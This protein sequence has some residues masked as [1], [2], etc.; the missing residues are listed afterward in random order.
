MASSVDVLIPW[1]GND[2]H[3]VKAREYVESLYAARFPEWKVTLGVCDSVGWTKALAVKDAFQRTNAEI[4][5]VADA[6]VWCEEIGLVISGLEKAE[7]AQPYRWV[8]RITDADTQRVFS[9]EIEARRGQLA[10]PEYSGFAGGGIVAMRRETYAA[11]PLDPRFVGW[12]HEDESWARALRRL[13]G[14]RWVPYGGHLYHFWHPPQERT[15]ERASHGS[16]ESWLLREQYRMCRADKSAMNELIAGI[17][18]D[19]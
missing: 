3:R 11:C 17:R 1:Q 2:P 6:D 16:P 15:G 9:G 12:G 7:W 4:V 10:R 13:H 14:P 18:L 5:I 19:V 8:R